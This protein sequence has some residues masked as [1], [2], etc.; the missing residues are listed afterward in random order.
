[1]RYTRGIPA[2]VVALLA[3]A[4]CD[5]SDSLLTPEP[6]P[7]TPIT[8]PSH[9]RDTDDEQA[10]VARE[11]IPGYAGY[12]LGTDGVPVVRLVNPEQAEEAQAYVMR[13]IG[14]ARSNRLPL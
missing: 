9:V 12:Y 13:T 2:A 5:S 6:S 10:R 3:T 11:E 4:A 1:M 7:T 8:A 14:M